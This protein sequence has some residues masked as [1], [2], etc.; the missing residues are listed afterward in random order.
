MAGIGR[1]KAPGVS[2]FVMSDKVYRTWCARRRNGRSDFL[3]LHSGHLANAFVRPRVNERRR[4]PARGCPR[5]DALASLTTPWRRASSRIG[6]GIREPL[7]I[8]RLRQAVRRDTAPRTEGHHDN[9]AWPSSPPH[10]KGQDH[11][12]TRDQGRET[13]R[14]PSEDGSYAIDP[15]ELARDRVLGCGREGRTEL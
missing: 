7:T 13:E 12:N 14:D 8:P 5:Q 10:W 1:S 6:S 15:S 3:R 2:D 11:A 9:D 4:T